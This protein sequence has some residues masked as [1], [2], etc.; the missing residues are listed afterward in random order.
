MNKVVEILKAKGIAKRI[1]SNVDKTAALLEMPISQEDIDRSVKLIVDLECRRD[2]EL[3][4]VFAEY[5]F[6]L[7]MNSIVKELGIKCNHEPDPIR[8]V[9]DEDKLKQRIA[10]ELAKCICQF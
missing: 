8:N 6:D 9:S 10:I 2:P 7:A 4:R 3:G 1:Q 5:A